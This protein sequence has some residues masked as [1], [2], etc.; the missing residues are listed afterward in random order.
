[1]E[2]VYTFGAFLIGAIMLVF[3]S[4]FLIRDTAVD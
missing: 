2:I 3:L 1:M 4:N